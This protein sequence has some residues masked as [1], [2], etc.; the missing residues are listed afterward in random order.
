MT[1]PFHFF[2]SKFPGHI[3]C[4]YFSYVADLKEREKGVGLGKNEVELGITYK[5]F[6]TKIVKFYVNNSFCLPP[7]PK[8]TVLINYYN[9]ITT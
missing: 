3:K 9:T 5:I 6:V 4:H 8:T 2:G 7:N 1:Q